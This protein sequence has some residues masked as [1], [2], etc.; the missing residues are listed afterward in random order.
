MVN[1]LGNPSIIPHPTLITSMTL[2]SPNS[3]HHLI[4]HKTTQVMKNN[5]RIYIQRE[6]LKVVLIKK[7]EENIHV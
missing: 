6:S 5:L 2:E 7:H 1:H 4:T 3:L